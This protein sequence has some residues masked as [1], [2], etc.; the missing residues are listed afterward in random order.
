M[1]FTLCFL[2]LTVRTGVW[3]KR[4]GKLLLPVRREDKLKRQCSAVR[5]SDE[6]WTPSPLGLDA[7][8]K[9]DQPVFSPKRPDFMEA[10]GLLPPYTPED[11]RMAY[12]EKAKGAHPDH[13]GSVGDFVK[14]QEAYERAVEYVQ[15]SADRR[16][17]LAAQV[18]RY[19]QQEQVLAEARRRGGEVEIEELDW[20]KRSIGDD[21]AVLTERLRGIRLRGL[22][23]GD[24]FLRDLARHR[25]A[26]Q[27]LVWLDLAGG[28][29]SDEGLQHLAC[30]PLIERL[31]LSG[32]RIT[33]RGLSVLSSLPQLRWLNLSGTSVGWWKRWRLHRSHRQVKIVAGLQIPVPST[34]KRLGVS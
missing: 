23:D 33:E 28:R 16:H 22:T 8:M 18:E 11:V 14:L 6:Y 21:F 10:L 5:D 25:P 20:L 2:S 19:V 34:A 24:P 9:T 13:G 30:M 32:A 3:G 1:G 31:D 12:R 4:R 26:L 27:Y 7:I 29:I 15:F 17:W